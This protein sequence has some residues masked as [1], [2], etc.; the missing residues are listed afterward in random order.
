MECIVLLHRGRG[1]DAVDLYGGG[2]VP[3]GKDKVIQLRHSL[4]L[5]QI[6]GTF[7]VVQ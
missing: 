2:G 4:T 5:L 7:V 3:Q 6:H 1:F